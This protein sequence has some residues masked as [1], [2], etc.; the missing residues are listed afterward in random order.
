L[1][2]LFVACCQNST[3][4]KDFRFREKQSSK[5]QASR[6]NNQFNEVLINQPVKFE[7]N[8]KMTGDNK[9]ES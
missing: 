5:V 9:L 6:V 4:V 2:K 1:G 7:L 8:S 3:E